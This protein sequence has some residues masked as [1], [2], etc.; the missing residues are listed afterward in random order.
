M[1]SNPITLVA[2][3]W[4]VHMPICLLGTTEIIKVIA[5]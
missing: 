2:C 5:R 4:H 1:E 3:L